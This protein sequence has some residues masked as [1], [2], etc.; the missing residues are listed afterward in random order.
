MS[1]GIAAEIADAQVK[2]SKSGAL[3]IA[4]KLSTEI[5]PQWGV[6][7]IR[8]SNRWNWYPLIKSLL[9][10]MEW[11]INDFENL[12]LKTSNE[13]ISASQMIAP[14]LIGKSILV[15]L[16]P[17]MVKDKLLMSTTILG[18]KNDR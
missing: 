13:I 8:E 5:G 7:V 1:E 18:A 15:R 16:K 4:L 11:M 6:L 2:F 12:P 17:I 3:Y 10:P 9:T 14:L